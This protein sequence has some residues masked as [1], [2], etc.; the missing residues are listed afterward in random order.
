MAMQDTSCRTIANTLR[1]INKTNNKLTAYPN[2]TLGNTTLDFITE[3]Y[4]TIQVYNMQGYLV[5]ELRN[6]LLKSV[7][8]NTTNFAKGVYVIR[9]TNGIETINT[10][11]ICE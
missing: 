3:D 10:K 2:P 5:K 8:L 7:E 11:I 6:E 1:K 4:W 9:A